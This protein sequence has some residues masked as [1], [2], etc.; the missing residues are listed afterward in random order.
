MVEHHSKYVLW[1]RRLRCGAIAGL[2]SISLVAAESMDL[3]ADWPLSS[4]KKTVETAETRQARDFNNAIRKLLAEAKA[5]ADRGEIDRAIYMADR[6]A[7][8]SESSAKLVQC[9]PDV[10]PTATANYV[11]ELRSLRSERL[12]RQGT[13]PEM[14]AKSLPATPP[15]GKNGQHAK[16]GGG[17]APGEV[18]ETKRKAGSQ[19]ALSSAEKTQSVAR[20]SGIPSSVA[21]LEQP[22]RALKGADTTDSFTGRS[23][24]SELANPA[25]ANTSTGH[26]ENAAWDPV[27]DVASSTFSPE[28]PPT[29]AP[30]SVDDPALDVASVGEAA[31]AAGPIASSFSG[32]RTDGSLDTGNLTGMPEVSGPPL[33]LRERQRDISTDTLS[34]SVEDLAEV[35]SSKER[36]IVAPSQDAGVNFDTDQ[37]DIEEDALAASL[38]SLPT[39]ASTGGLKLRSRYQAP[40]SQTPA[41][42]SS[43]ESSAADEDSAGL[44]MPTSDE[45]VAFAPEQL[46]V[47]E[48]QDVDNPKHSA[49]LKL[50]S[51]Y[52]EKTAQVSDASH[53][54]SESAQQY[55][56]AKELPANGFPV[57]Q[58][59]ELRR[60]LEAK[61]K[62]NPGEPVTTSHETG[63]SAAMERATAPAVVELARSPVSTPRTSLKLRKSYDRAADVIPVSSEVE[64]KPLIETATSKDPKGEAYKN[65]DDDADMI[66]SGPSPSIID[67]PNAPDTDSAKFPADQPPLRLRKKVTKGNESASASPSASLTQPE[68]VESA[69]SVAPLPPGIDQTEP[70]SQ[71]RSVPVK[72]TKVGMQSSRDSISKSAVPATVKTGGKT[73][74]VVAKASGKTALKRQV[75]TFEDDQAAISRSVMANGPVQRFAQMFN[76]PQKTAASTMGVVGVVMMI[77]GLWLIRAMLRVNPA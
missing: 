73:A 18:A 9:A 75:T 5:H 49:G 46:S 61:S 31:Q 42:T 65:S 50:R 29:E 10:S 17:S 14:L 38:S 37:V 54:S 53:S 26:G 41:V 6:A 33:K 34:E 71:S 47:E 20:K 66:P 62:F 19:T 44:D 2:T 32:D 77:G 21:N 3:R 39:E 63:E 57:E 25:T 55:P 40:S 28:G 76:L 56:S 51:R 23:E 24:S 48:P 8:I 72:A 59:Y 11:S 22:V 1:A 35:T 30:P 60:R 16:V 45:S 13:T 36:P 4:R 74:A 7:S 15:G 43:Q 64:A 70:T 58:V 68:R 27:F 52:L 12:K 67:L 69:A